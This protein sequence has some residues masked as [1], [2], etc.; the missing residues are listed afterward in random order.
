MIYDNQPDNKH[1]I[2][3]MRAAIINEYSLVIWDERMVEKDINGA[4]VEM[5]KGDRAKLM[6]YIEERTFR[7]SFDNE[8]KIRDEFLNWSKIPVNFL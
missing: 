6:A 4:L 1:I 5:F 7:F 8:M 3:E 2:K